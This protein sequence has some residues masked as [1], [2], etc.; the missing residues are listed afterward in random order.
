[1]TYDFSLF[2]VGLVVGLLL[3]LGHSAALLAPK[4]TRS[5][6]QKFCRNTLVGRVLLV[7]AT[8]WAVYLLGT[9]DLGEFAGLRPMLVVGTVVAGVLTWIFVEEFLAVR[10][11]AILLLLAAEILLCAAYLQPPVAR[12]W[13]VFLAYGWILGGL[14]FIGLPWLL[15]D[16]INW[17][18]AK[19]WRWQLSAGAGIAY[20]AILVVSALLWY[21]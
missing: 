10:A 21:R 20:G 17:A 12:L 9:I 4:L 16:L 2:A 6:L 18:V 11:L 15:R 3:I 5:E 13:L 14:F 19:P 1:M 8:A 7:V